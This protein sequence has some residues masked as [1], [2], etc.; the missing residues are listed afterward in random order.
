MNQEQIQKLNKL[1]QNLLSAFDMD[2]LAECHEVLF[3]ILTEEENLY[4]NISNN[5]KDSQ[6]A[7]EVERVVKL[8]NKAEN[9]LVDAV[10]LY[11]DY[12]IL[13]KGDKDDFRDKVKDTIDCIDEI[14]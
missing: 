12:E 5:L 1:K 7:V 10:F 11:E 3:D 8:L 6:Q 4:N 9:A 14:L 13:F 2:A